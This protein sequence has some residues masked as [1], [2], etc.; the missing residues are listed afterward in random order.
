MD[1]HAPHPPLEEYYRGEEGRRS[2]VRR[3]F[4]DTAVDY[5][6]V[7]RMMALGSGS[8][9]RR[10]ALRRAGLVPGMDVLD[11]AVGTGLVAREAVAIVGDP[12]R[13]VGLD[14][15]IG[16]LR[17]AS[18]PLSI[19]TV[20]GTAERLPFP[21][22]RFD[23]VSMGFALRHMSDLSVVFAELLRV[24][25]PGGR[26]CILEITRPSGPLSHLIVRTYMRG[27]VP[28]L[29][30][31]VARHRDTARLMRYYWDTIEACV[32]PQRVVDGLAAAGFAGARRHVELGIFSEYTGRKA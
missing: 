12:R 28:M 13:V 7:E 4:D 17:S 22:D 3:I 2:F 26:A 11:V 27:V 23:F 10:R 15:S 31:V 5:D 20:Q 30:K 24:L 21:S 29:A 8:W 32:P 1:L 6:R 18:E 16:M 19:V 14:P 9:Y 25:K